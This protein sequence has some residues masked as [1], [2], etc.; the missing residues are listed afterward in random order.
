MQ[1]YLL[2]ESR[3]LFDSGDTR[4]IRDLATRL[5]RA[6]NSRVWYW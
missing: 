2:I 5:A 3:D 6:G 1:S 4:L